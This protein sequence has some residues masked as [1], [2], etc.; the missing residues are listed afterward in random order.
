MS[1]RTSLLTTI[2]KIRADVYTKYDIR[3]SYLTIRTRTWAGEFIGQG[4]FTDSDLVFPPHFAVRAVT[5]Q[6]VEG[7]GGR[8]KLD[9]ITVNHITPW[10]GGSIGYKPEQLQPPQAQNVEVL[11]IINGP[12]PGEFELVDCELLRPFSYKLVL[13]RLL[14]GNQSQSP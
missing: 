3:T 7:S 10:D 14:R 6:D 12:D 13:R 8:Y 9:D 5:S 4:S 2:G 11:Y 1:F